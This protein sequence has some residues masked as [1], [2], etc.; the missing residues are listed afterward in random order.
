[1]HN[2]HLASQTIC[3]SSYSLATLCEKAMELH[4]RIAS[5]FVGSLLPEAPLTG[6]VIL[7]P[8]TKLT[9]LML[10]FVWWHVLAQSATVQR[11]MAKFR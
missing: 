5:I 9:I 7:E 3:M 2:L 8:H 11:T 1:M 10:D 6:Q 4:D